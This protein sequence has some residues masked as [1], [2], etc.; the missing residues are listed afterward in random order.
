MMEEMIKTKSSKKQVDELTESNGG[1]EHSFTENS[2]VAM[3]VAEI[4]IEGYNSKKAEEQEAQRLEIELRKKQAAD[5]ERAR[6]EQHQAE[7]KKLEEQRKQAEE[8]FRLMK[9][10]TMD[11]K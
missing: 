7:M 5:E 2:N 6:Q 1:V 11:E 9:Q 3:T 4:E 10:K 8:E